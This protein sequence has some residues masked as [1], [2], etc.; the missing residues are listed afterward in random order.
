MGERIYPIVANESSHGDS[1]FVAFTE[2][3]DEFGCLCTFPTNDTFNG[4]NELDIE[5]IKSLALFGAA[6]HLLMSGE[7]DGP[8]FIPDGL[9]RWIV[10]AVRRIR[11]GATDAADPPGRT[12]E[13]G[14]RVV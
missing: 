5:R 1:D 8:V 11:A 10:D 2:M 7:L 4:I 3:D 12:T 14:E 9:P 6:V 13:G